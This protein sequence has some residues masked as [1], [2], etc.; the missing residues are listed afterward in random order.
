[1][2]TDFQNLADAFEAATSVM[3]VEVAEDGSFRELR[4]VTGNQAYI[5]S[6]ERPAGDYRMKNNKFVP[7]TI[8]T[9]YV[10]RDLNFEDFCYRSAVQKKCLHSY[11]KPNQMPI[12]FNMTFMPVGPSEGNVH[13]CTYT[14]EVN[15]EAD[16]E[17]MSNVSSEVASEVLE[18]CIKLRGTKDFKAAIQDVIRD[19]RHMCNA[20][21]CSILLMDEY[22]EKTSV[23]CMDYSGSI[24]IRS[25]SKNALTP[26]KEGFYK[27]AKTWK[28]LIGSSNCIIAKDARDMEYVKERDPLWYDTLVASGV[29]SIALFPLK[30]G[31]ELLGYIW[32]M[33]FDAV[34]AP[35]IKE[36]LELTTFILGS[37]INN[38]LLLDR[39]KELSSKDMLTGVMNRNE[40]NNY[41]DRL[42]ADAQGE[43]QSIGVVFADL[44][45]LKIVNDKHGHGRGDAM[46]RDAAKAL[47]EIY[48]ADCIFRAGGDEFTVILPGKSEDEINE[49]IAQLQ[50][51]IP[52]YE[53]L[54]MAIGGYVTGDS[55]DI[56]EALR[57]ADERMY[58]DKR[59]FYAKHPEMVRR[60]S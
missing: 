5:D 25:G 36:T 49:S 39:L 13:Y 33:N 51:T 8:Y 10:P 37:E 30:F 2:A 3:A 12:W 32:A 14:M 50:Q 60:P 24:G 55:H 9:D 15:F 11:V 59:S 58:E 27:V 53:Q 41:V 16:T 40:M 38:Y 34:N 1:M 22:E 23:L 54:S 47:Q 44:N 20:E 45:G 31:D 29:K 52:K 18:T 46:L 4:V 43:K 48:P 42:V 56:R 17:R 19:I 21:Q 28:D 6:I 57:K 35:K 7:N 26:R